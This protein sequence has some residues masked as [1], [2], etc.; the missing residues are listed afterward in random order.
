MYSFTPISINVNNGQSEVVDLKP[1]GIMGFNMNN[2]ELMKHLQIKASVTK[3]G[4]IILQ[5]S[6]CFRLLGPLE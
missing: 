3:Y 5:I 2:C 1:I 4:N 6:F